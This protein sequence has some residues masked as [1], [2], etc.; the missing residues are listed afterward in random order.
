M[1]YRENNHDVW[2][3]QE[4]G[5]IGEPSREPATDGLINNGIHERITKDRVEETI[6]R[7]DEIQSQTR[8]V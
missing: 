7:P 5:F 2:F 6:H 3:N 8:D 1:E 4:K